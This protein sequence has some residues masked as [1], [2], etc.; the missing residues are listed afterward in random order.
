MVGETLGGKYRII[1]LLGQ[2]GMGAVYEAQLAAS[3]RRVAVK[4]MHGA[5]LQGGG[6]AL[7][8]F[9]REARTVAMLD[10]PHI[11]SV[12]DAGA[13][14]A[15]GAPFMVMERLEG[16]DLHQRLR[17]AGALAP[18]AALRIAAQACRGLSRA[19]EMRIVHRDIKPA[20]LF[21]AR[22]D[23]GEIAVKLLDFG[24]AKIKEQAA[25]GLT[26]TTGLTQS[27][28]ILGSPHFMSP[29]QARGLRDID[30]RTDIWS[31]GVV[32]YHALTGHVPHEH[33]HALGDLILAICTEGP[34]PIR[35]RAPWVPAEV[36]ALVQRALERDPDRRFP[37][38]AAMLDAMG[39][40]LPAGGWALDEQLLARPAPREVAA[41]PAPEAGRDAPTVV[42]TVEGVERWVVQVG[43]ASPVSGTDTTVPAPGPAGGVEPTAPSEAAGAPAARRRARAS[44]GAGEQVARRLRHGP[45]RARA[46]HA[47][48][49]ALAATVALGVACFFL[50]SGTT[51]TLT[52]TSATRAEKMRERVSLAAGISVPAVPSSVVDPSGTSPA[53]PSGRVPGIMGPRIMGPPPAASPAGTRVRGPRKLPVTAPSARPVAKTNEDDSALEGPIDPRLGY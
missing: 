9:Q 32:L 53:S 31:L 8:R 19:H 20:N 12:I 52:P 38:A 35:A 11:V 5:A 48:A 44:L 26:T 36:A 42:G 29:E 6:L 10:D 34:P 21:L 15:T 14:P 33:I 49:L 23:Q 41:A 50:L 1:R 13:D 28:A 30:H 25:Q 47:A 37:S 7:K 3:E 51:R 2:G 22:V 18:E 17:R 46:S 16:E 27:G 39:P 43:G 4:V 45:F 24:I 40:L